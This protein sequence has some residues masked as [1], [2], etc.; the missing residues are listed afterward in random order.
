[1]PMPIPL[2]LLKIYFFKL[3]NDQIRAILY[4][5]ISYLKSPTK[6]FFN[7]TKHTLEKKPKRLFLHTSRDIDN[8]LLR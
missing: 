8:E 6:S 7:V 1:M 2:E 4:R 3:E 5:Q